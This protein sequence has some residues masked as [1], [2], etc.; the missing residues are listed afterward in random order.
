MEHEVIT[1]IETITRKFAPKE[2]AIG[3]WLKDGTILCQ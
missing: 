3:E 2:N 1:W